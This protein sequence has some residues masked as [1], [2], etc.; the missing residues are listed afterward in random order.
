MDKSTCVEVFRSN[1]C[2]LA[3][4]T[5]TA[6][7]QHSNSLHLRDCVNRWV[8]SRLAPG[9]TPTNPRVETLIVAFKLEA[10]QLQQDGLLDEL[11]PKP[12]FCFAREW[13][14]WRMKRG[15]DGSPFTGGPFFALQ[16]RIYTGGWNGTSIPR[17]SRCLASDPRVNEHPKH[18]ICLPS[19]L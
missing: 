13:H 18:A 14:V 11:M 10:S 9:D 4:R 3:E 12:A 7:C 17:P 5:A 1:K 8:D 19:L 2:Y 6:R 15:I 16:D